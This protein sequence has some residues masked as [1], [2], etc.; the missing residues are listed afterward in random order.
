MDH[1]FDVVIVGAGPAGCTCAYLL[2]GKG[3][4]IA[5]IEKSIFPRDK[6]CGDALSPDVINQLNLINPQWIEQFQK[7]VAKK[8]S[9]GI[10][11]IAPNF[12]MLDINFNQPEGLKLDGF[13]AKRIDFDHFMF[14]QIKRLQD[15]TIFQGQKVESLE[16]NREEINIFT[17]DHKIKCKMVMGA[18]GAQSVVNRA[19]SDN[20]IDKKHYCAGVRQYF[21][22][23]EGMEHNKIEL[24]FYRELLPGY[25][26]IFSLPNNQANVGMG[27]LSDEISRNKI[28]LKEMLRSLL[29]NHPNLKDRFRNALPLEEIKGFGLPIGSRKV[30]CSGDGFLLLGDAACLIDPF[31]GEGIGNA[32]R[33]GRIAAKHLLKAFT[34]K[35]F[36]AAFNKSYDQKLYSKMWAELRISRKM[37]M[38]LRYPWIFNLLV[39]KA[40]RNESLHHLL[41]SMITD[42]DL[43]KELRKPSFYAK[44]FFR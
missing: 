8:P 3:L 26:W 30:Q 4:N 31:T 6:V 9:E 12:R 41:T 22:G 20:K 19:L 42:P 14:N 18:D 32:I 38:L 5:L 1:D 15:I 29:S 39:K 16:R 33:S 23:I 34:E 36:D 27:M 28:D 2:A 13:V 40:E 25:F 7:S 21:S 11:L 17:N 44:L 10:R 24:H 37:Q 35:R 43:R